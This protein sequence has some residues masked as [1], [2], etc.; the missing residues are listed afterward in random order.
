MANGPLPI[1]IVLIF[2]NVFVSITE[3]FLLSGLLIY[4]RF[5]LLLTTTPAGRCP[6]AIVRITVL[7]LVSITETEL[8]P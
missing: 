2:V 1:F 8:S 7:V 3:I 4:T 5:P 6:T